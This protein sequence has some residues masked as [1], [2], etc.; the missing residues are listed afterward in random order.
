GM[1]RGSCLST[2]GCSNSFPTING[3]G[4]KIG[5][6]Y[7]GTVGFADHLF[8]MSGMPEYRLILRIQDF[9]SR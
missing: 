3:A 5:E 6:Q 2:F 1:M 7:A 9:P 8:G 4:R